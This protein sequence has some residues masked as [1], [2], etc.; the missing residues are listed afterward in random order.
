MITEAGGDAEETF[1]A[2]AMTSPPAG[3]GLATF[4]WPFKV[5]P[6]K[7]VVPLLNSMVSACEE[8]IPSGADA[9]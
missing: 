1:D 9:V 6:P 8:L 4:T 2:S 7:T 3:A 5:P